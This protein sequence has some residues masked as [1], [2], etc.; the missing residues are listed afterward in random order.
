MAEEHGTKEIKDVLKFVLKGYKAGVAAYADGKISWDDVGHLMPVL[1][2]AGPAFENIAMTIKEAKDLSADEVEDLFLF[3]KE[4]L[5]VDDKSK[6]ARIINH[7]IG[8]VIHGFGMY[9]VINE[10]PDVEA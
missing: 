7:A 2:H 4:E 1:P 3:V 5:G 6:A 10:K 9:A 8:I